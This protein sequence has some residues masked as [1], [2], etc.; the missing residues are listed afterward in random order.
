MEPVTQ[1][2]L[3]YEFAA[4]CFDGEPID[5]S[6]ENPWDFEWRSLGGVVVVPH[7]TYPR[8]RHELNLY[9]IQANGGLIEFAAGE[10]S[11]GVWV[12]Y[13]RSPS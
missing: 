2:A 6:G 3:G 1:N 8:Q 10:V 9:S 4:I 11:E 12:F 5:V 7:P 13:L